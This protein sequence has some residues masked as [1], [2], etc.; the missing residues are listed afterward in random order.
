MKT[1][2]AAISF[3]IA[4]IGAGGAAVQAPDITG[5]WSASFETQIGTQN[6]TYDFVVKDS[7][8]TGHAKSNLG[9][10]DLSEGKVNGDTVTFI[11]NLKM[12]GMDLRIDYKGKIVSADEIKFT[13]Q[14]G[15]IATEELVA[16][17]VK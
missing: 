8:L 17:R 15:D 9:E 6:Y 11:E 1:F 12:E 14:V 16:K 13:R 2:L 3:A 10:G 4:A 5:K 7:V